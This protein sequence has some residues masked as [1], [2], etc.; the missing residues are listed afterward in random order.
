MSQSTSSTGLEPGRLRSMLRT[1][2][3]VRRRG[4]CRAGRHRASGSRSDRRRY[5]A[6]GDRGA[7]RRLML[8]STARRGSG[9]RSGVEMY[10]VA[11]RGRRARPAKLSTFALVHGA[12]HGAWCWERL[13]AVRSRTAA[14]QVV[15]PEAAIG[16]PRR[17]ASR[18]TPDDD[19][20]AATPRRCRRRRCSCPHSLGGLVGPVVRRAAARCRALG[21][22]ST[23][24]GARA[25][26]RA[27]RSSCGASSGAGA[28]CSRAGA[29]VDD[30][31]RSYWR[32]P[33]GH[34]A[35]HVRRPRRPRTRA[36]RPSACAPQAQ[37]SQ[38][39]PLASSAAR[40]CA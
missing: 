16:G 25:G 15:A 14:T 19:R 2:R 12:W 20:R 40:G 13:I 35:H 3:A 22:P 24:P 10:A 4:P 32:R 18:R 11:F 8:P 33:G 30:Q 21:L 31:G 36:G 1:D 27:S 28:C 17:P 7:R 26:P 38:T 5:S 29:L 34:G 39:E 37:R 9:R 23:A 6:G